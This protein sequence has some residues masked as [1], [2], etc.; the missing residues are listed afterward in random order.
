MFVRGRDSSHFCFQTVN[1][2]VNRSLLL[3]IH[4]VIQVPD[5]KLGNQY[6]ANSLLQHQNEIVRV[7]LGNTSGN[8]NKLKDGLE[9]RKFL[10]DHAWQKVGIVSAS[11]SKYS[12]I[13]VQVCPRFSMLGEL[14]IG[15]RQ[16]RSHL[17][18]VF[19]LIIIVRGIFVLRQPSE[20]KCDAR[21]IVTLFCNMNGFVSR[22][23]R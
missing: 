13:T 22:E 20:S 15:S 3:R 9:H 8:R 5:G 11:P 7:A 10:L 12:R 4:Q 2:L 23:T 6:V 18:R 16:Q 21:R 14:Q 17:T 19:S 1:Q